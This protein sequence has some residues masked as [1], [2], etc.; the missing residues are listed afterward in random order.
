MN[1]EVQAVENVR[2]LSRWNHPHIVIIPKKIVD[3][4]PV[5]GKVA[6]FH[7]FY[8][9]TT[10]PKVIE[11]LK[12]G[13]G[14]GVDY[15]IFGTVVPA[16]VKAPITPGTV[17]KMP[18]EK[19]KDAARE[20]VDAES[21]SLVKAIG[22]RISGLEKTVTDLAG[23]VE[24]LIKGRIDR[25]EEKGVVSEGTGQEPQTPSKKKAGRP[26]KPKAKKAVVDDES[27]DDEES[28]EEA[29]QTAAEGK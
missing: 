11:V 1:D 21:S 5:D 23:I 4:N 17:E 14:F 24:V 16:M 29:K 2:F 27:G 18:G 3:G 13:P 12:K 10:D 9:D 20:N 19:A 28:S 8:Y 22:Q 25:D 7:D 6:E 26:G 15:W